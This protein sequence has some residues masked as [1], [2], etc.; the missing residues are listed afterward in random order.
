MSDPKRTAE[1]IP[2]LIWA[3]IKATRQ[4]YS[5]VCTK[6]DVEPLEG[7]LLRLPTATLDAYTFLLKAELPIEVDGIP[8]Q[9]L[10]THKQPTPMPPATTPKPTH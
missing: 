6:E 7:D 2:Q 5:T 9:W 3:I 10:L 1:R 8:E 4:F